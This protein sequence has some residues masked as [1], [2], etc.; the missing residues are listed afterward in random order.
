MM[1]NLCKNVEEVKAKTCKDINEWL[2]DLPAVAIKAEYINHPEV[3]HRGD[4][5]ENGNLIKKA[6]W[7][8]KFRPDDKK[9]ASH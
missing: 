3:P 2:N 8:V 6:V 5:D 9:E 7:P 1:V 4:R